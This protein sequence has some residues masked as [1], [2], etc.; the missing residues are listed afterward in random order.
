MNQRKDG[1]VKKPV[2]V[3][4]VIVIIL[5]LIPASV[6]VPYQKLEN[7]D[8]SYTAQETYEVQVPYQENY[9]AQVSVQVQVPYNDLEYYYV[10]EPYTDTIPVDYTVITASYNNYIFTPP[11]YMWVTIKNGDIKSGYF[12]VKFDVTTQGGATT[13]LTASEFILPSEQKQVKTSINDK[14]STYNYYVTPPTK[15]VTKYHDV[16]KSR[17]VTKYRT[18]TQYK[19][20]LRTRD[21]TRTE[22]RTRD[23]TKT[24]PAQR[25][26]TDYMQKNVLMF[27]KLFGMY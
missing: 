24:R 23:V 7:Y 12:T 27:Q 18:E 4:M 17:T 22:T 14:I 2:A 5:A 19:T 15:D 6:T 20:E 25:Y 13:S 10:S 11:S 9:E 1:G 3:S 26:V 8:E 21:A 16:Q